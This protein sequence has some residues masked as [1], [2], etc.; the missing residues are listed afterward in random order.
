MRR[1]RS[2]MIGCQGNGAKGSKRWV[3]LPSHGAAGEN[4]VSSRWLKT[5]SWKLIQRRLGMHASRTL[6]CIRFI[7]EPGA[8]RLTERLWKEVVFDLLA[9][10]A[11]L[12]VSVSGKCPVN[13]VTSSLANEEPLA[14]ELRFLPVLPESSGQPA[15]ASAAVV[16]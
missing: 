6:A 2:E 8:T 12:P 13:L 15:R 4:A 16:T 9:C 7:K 11:R 10:C 5:T 14:G 3:S 1:Y